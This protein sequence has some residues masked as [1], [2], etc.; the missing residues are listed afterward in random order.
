[1]IIFHIFYPIFIIY[2]SFLFSSFIDSKYII[3]GLSL[4]GI[5]LFSL[6]FNVLFALFELKYFLISSLLISFLGLIAFS[7]SWIKVWY[8]ILFI[9]IFW[10]VSNI[11]YIFWIFLVIKKCKLN[12]HFY[13]SFIF[14]YG[15][16]KEFLI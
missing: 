7:V 15:I 8:P 13:S 10:L 3:I 12:Q 16:F 4:I 9:S 2:Y 6:L 5:E 1:M 11:Y 14:S